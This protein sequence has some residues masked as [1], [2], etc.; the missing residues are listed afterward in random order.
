[1]SASVTFHLFVRRALDRMEGVDP[2]GAPAVAARLVS[3]LGPPGPRE[4][5]QDA[6]LSENDGLPRVEAHETAGSHDIAAHARANALIRLPGGAGPLE[7][8]TVVTGV[9][10]DR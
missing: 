7:K 10:L 3:A 4:T 9:L 1:V 6:L 2:P 8:E 5:Y